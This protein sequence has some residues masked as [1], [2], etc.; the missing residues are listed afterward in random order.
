MHSTLHPNRNCHHQITY[1]KFDLKAHCTLPYVQELWHYE[2]GNVDHK[3]T[4]CK[5][6]WERSFENNIL[7][8]IKQLSNN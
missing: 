7:L 2:K 3:R 6:L 8:S 5:F 1:A 4:I